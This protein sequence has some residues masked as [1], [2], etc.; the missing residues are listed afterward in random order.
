MT[1]E[2]ELGENLVFRG[3]IKNGKRFGFGELI[4]A[5]EFS[6]SGIWFA[7]A[8]QMTEKIYSQKT[9]KPLK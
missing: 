1:E 9:I 7:N 6:L 8:I 5:H 3:S 4:R 2:I